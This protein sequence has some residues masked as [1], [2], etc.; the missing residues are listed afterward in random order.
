MCFVIIYDDDENIFVYFRAILPSKN[1]DYNLYFIKYLSQV[2][3]MTYGT[4]N[5]W[6]DNYQQ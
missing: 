2:R 4:T 1:L 6:T 5:K 3:R